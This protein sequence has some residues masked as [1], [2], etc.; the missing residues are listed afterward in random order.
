MI[1]SSVLYVCRILCALH[2][3]KNVMGMKTFFIK[4][5]AHRGKNNAE[6]RR[7]MAAKSVSF[8]E[9]GDIENLYRNSSSRRV[10][11]YD[12]N[13]FLLFMSIS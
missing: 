5:K 1:S 10:S 3:W 2:L 12:E 11:I 9:I 8:K 4:I 13:F 7:W 6:N